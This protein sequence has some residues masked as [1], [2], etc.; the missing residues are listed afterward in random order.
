[1][2]Q[3]TISG[4]VNLLGW[5]GKRISVWEKYDANG[6]EFSRLWT[7][8]FQVSQ[9]DQIQEQDWVTI[10]GELSTKIGQYTNKAGEEK[11][12][13]EHHIQ[14]AHLGGTVTKQQQIANA[15]SIGG[16]ENA[17]F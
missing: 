10:S 1:M 12:V 5:E 7:C 2:P 14:N 3:I 8:W 4:D 11:T 6:K 13:V 15:A 9:A 17:P 16:F